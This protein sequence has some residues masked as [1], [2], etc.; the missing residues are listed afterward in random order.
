MFIFILFVAGI[1]WIFDQY[2]GGGYYVFYGGLIGA[3]IYVLITYYSGAKM[4]LAMNGAK[5]IQKSDNPRLYR[6]V[7]NLAITNGMPMPKVYVIDDPAANAFATGRD[8]KHSAVAATTGILDLM[9]DTELEGVIAMSS[10]ILKTTISESA[11]WPL[12]LQR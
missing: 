10:G 11:W 4:A 7:E 5:E 1:I 8:P 12:R 2:L 6:I 9:T 3:S